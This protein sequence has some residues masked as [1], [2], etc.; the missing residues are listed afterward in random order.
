[1]AYG[2]GPYGDTVYGGEESAKYF[3]GDANCSPVTPGSLELSFIPLAGPRFVLGHDDGN[4]N[5]V[6]DA[7]FLAIYPT[8]SVSGSIDYRTGEIDSGLVSTST[9]ASGAGSVTLSYLP[10]EGGC[11]GVGCGGCKTHKFRLLVVPGTNIGE[12]QITVSEAFARLVKK[13]AAITPIHATWEPLKLT[14]DLVIQVVE[15]YDLTSADE[16]PTDSTGLYTIWT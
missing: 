8:G 12:N 10:Q 14:E 15:H 9:W 1:M 13:I 6:A 2:S 16:H 4:G 11:S 5:I 7:E 3:A